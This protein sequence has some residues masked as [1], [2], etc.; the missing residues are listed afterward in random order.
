MRKIFTFIVVAAII[1]IL[2]FIAIKDNFNL[3]KIIIDLEKQTDLK[4]TLNNESKWN[5]YPLIKFNNNITINDNANFLV[6]NNADIDISKNYW[7][8][9]PIKINLTTPSINVEGIQLRNA[10]IKSSYKNKN[11]FI[12]KISS[13]LIEGN[14]IAQGKINIINEMP[15]EELILKF[16]LRFSMFPVL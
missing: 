2:I 13:K 10:I 8:T 6:I 9:S 14:I 1:L 15:F 11:I 7:P 4:I 3:N 12:E 5:Y 16:L